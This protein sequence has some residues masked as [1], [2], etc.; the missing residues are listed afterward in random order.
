[1]LIVMVVSLR[2][3]FRRFMD[4]VVGMLFR[5]ASFIVSCFL[6]LTFWGLSRYLRHLKVWEDIMD[7]ADELLMSLQLAAQYADLSW[8]VGSITSG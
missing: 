3:G 2:S 6:G 8:L 5:R 4:L 1:M 7:G